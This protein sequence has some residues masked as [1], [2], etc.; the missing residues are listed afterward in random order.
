MGAHHLFR[1]AAQFSNA[2]RDRFWPV[3][4]EQHC[5]TLLA[6]SERRHLRLDVAVAL[7][8]HANIREDNREQ[9]GLNNTLAKELHRRE[10]KP[11]LLHFRR[12]GGEAAW[13]RPANIWPVSRVREKRPEASAIE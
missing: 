12:A 1:P 5:Q 6:D 11:F 4:I 10:P 2:C 8:R 3:S 9:V 13:Y 7:F